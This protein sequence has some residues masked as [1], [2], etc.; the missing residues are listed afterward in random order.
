MPSDDLDTRTAY[1][2]ND[3]MMLDT[4][5]VEYPLSPQKVV[6]PPSSTEKQR[7]PMYDLRDKDREPYNGDSESEDELASPEGNYASY[8]NVPATPCPIG[9]SCTP[10]GQ[11]GN[12]RLRSL[13]RST[14]KRART[15]DKFG[16]TP[17]ANQL[18]GWTTGPSPLKTGIHTKSLEPE[19]PEELVTI[20]DTEIPSLEASHLGNTFFD[21]AMLSRPVEATG[22]EEGTPPQ[23]LEIIQG[24]R[25]GAARIQ[26]YLDH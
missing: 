21:D 3:P 22:D 7:G 15:D 9:A 2:D 26:R 24:I 12:D 20:V 23:E 10:R 14:A 1:D 6:S 18:S 4:P 17:L 13:G 25:G 8:D 5:Y 11:I 19:V 16:F